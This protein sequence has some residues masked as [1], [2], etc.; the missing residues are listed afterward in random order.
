MYICYVCMYAMQKY[1]HNC[2]A[3]GPIVRLCQR[4]FIL[5]AFNHFFFPLFAYIKYMYIFSH[6]INNWPAVMFCVSC[7]SPPTKSSVNLLQTL[8][9]YAFKGLCFR[10]F[11]CIYDT[12]NVN[13]TTLINDY[14][15]EHITS[16]KLALFVL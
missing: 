4:Q 7:E 1:L 3:A 12:N 11:V 8:L 10:K 16:K 2:T 15:W 9:D 6:Y 14:T 5:H 13:D